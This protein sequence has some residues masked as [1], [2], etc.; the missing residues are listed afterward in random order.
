MNANGLPATICSDGVDY[1]FYAENMLIPFKILSG[2]I[3]YDGYVK[4]RY[5]QNNKL[6][7]RA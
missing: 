1:A 6:V 3:G 5:K 2:D 7:Y 4:G